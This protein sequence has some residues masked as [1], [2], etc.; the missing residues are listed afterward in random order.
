MPSRRWNTITKASVVAGLALLFIW[1]VVMFSTMIPGTI[2][3]FLLAFVL[4]YPVNWIQ[5]QTGWARTPAIVLVYCAILLLVALMPILILPRATTLYASLQ[6]TL[7]DLINSLQTTVIAVGRFHMPV[8]DLLGPLSEALQNILRVASVNPWS[9]FRGLTD[10]LLIAIYVLVL[11]FWL[12]KDLQKLQRL[13]MD[14]IPTDY[15]EDVRRL[16]Q[17]ITQIWEGFLRG[18]I[19]LGVVIGLITWVVLSILGMH[20]AGGLAL[21]AGV[22]ELLP[23]V[24]P[25]ISGTIGTLVALFQGSTWLPVSHITFALIISATYAILG[26]IESVYFIPRLVGGRVKLHPAVAFVSVIAGALVFGA[27]GVLLA[28]PVVAT[29]RTLLTYTYRKL[30][31][32]EPF[33]PRQTTQMGIRIRGLVGGRK[34]EAIIFDLDGVL[35]EVDWRAVTWAEERLTWLDRIIPSAQRGHYMRRLMIGAEGMVNFLI[36]QLGRAHNQRELEQ[37]LPLFNQLRGYPPP[38]QLTLQPGVA[39]TL[40]RL[41]YPY[42]LALISARDTRS[43]RNF[44]SNAALDDGVFAY[45]VTREDVRSLLP[46]SE[47]LL[48]LAE[49]LQLA[50]DQILIVSDTDTNLRAGRAMG[51]AVVGVLSGLGE[52]QDMDETDLTISS[53]PELEEW[54]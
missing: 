19:V 41:A 45:V 31:D 24:G 20:N 3:A 53:L 37:M 28:T 9:I 30:L 17:E 25:A 26:Q 40:H 47:S 14:Q 23:T 50:P 42:R 54:L 13:L 43:V 8:N 35:T 38:E 7:I 27:L 15:Q 29:L 21:L 33:E 4:S 18:Q 16:A 49:R 6:Q 51:M 48:Y 2:V 34:I 12:L 1:A 22:L 39:E 11:N 36:S 46:H 32:Q 52:T 10:G 44:L 5:R